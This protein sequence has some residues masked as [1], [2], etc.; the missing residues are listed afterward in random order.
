MSNKDSQKSDL[1]SIIEDYIDADEHIEHIYRPSSAWV[2]FR[3]FLAI[4]IFGLL[5]IFVPMN[6]FSNPRSTNFGDPSMLD[7][8]GPTI[9]AFLTITISLILTLYVAYN[10][11]YY[12]IT[13]KRFILIT[14]R[15]LLRNTRKS[16]NIDSVKDITSS[17]IPRKITIRSDTGT[18]ISFLYLLDNDE[19]KSECERAV[20]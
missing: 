1:P 3:M 18:K 4:L 11:Y 13:D 2:T 16:I 7:I 8:F 14:S 19:V 20:S 5:S 10:S 6:F 15:P 9:T 12:I 17:S